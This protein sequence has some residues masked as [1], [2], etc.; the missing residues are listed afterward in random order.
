[1]LGNAW[2]SEAFPMSSACRYERAVSPALRQCA[3]CFYGHEHVRQ[4]TAWVVYG[5]PAGATER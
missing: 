3:I 1:M 4:Q 2:G 5:M